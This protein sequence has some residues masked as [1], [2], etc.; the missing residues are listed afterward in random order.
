MRF[1]VLGKVFFYLGCLGYSLYFIWF[2]VYLKENNNY[3]FFSFILF[4]FNFVIFFVGCC[5]GGINFEEMFFLV[6]F[7][8]VINLM[9]CFIMLIC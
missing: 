4:Y 8:V 5:I 1:L 2:F 3:W 9:V 6:L 7:G